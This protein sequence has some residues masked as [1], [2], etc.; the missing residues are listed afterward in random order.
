M[1]KFIFSNFRT[2]P[3]SSAVNLNKIKQLKTK[4]RFTDDELGLV[5]NV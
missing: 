1:I 2:K 5:R 4:F 3:N